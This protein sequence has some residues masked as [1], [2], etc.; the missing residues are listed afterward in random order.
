MGYFTGFHEKALFHQY[1]GSVGASNAWP[2]LCLL[3]FTHLSTSGDFPPLPPLCALPVLSGN[4]FEAFG[5]SSLKS[6]ASLYSPVSWCTSLLSLCGLSSYSWNRRLTEPGSCDKAGQ[7]E[8]LKSGDWHISLG[9]VGRWASSVTS[10]TLN[11][12][13]SKVRSGIVVVN[14][15]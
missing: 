12:R 5:F 10:L 3:P 14:G 1:E 13:I 15:K 2:L 8:L 7:A 11:F 9:S 6:S 4:S